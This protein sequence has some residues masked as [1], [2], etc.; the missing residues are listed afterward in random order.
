[1]LKNLVFDFGN[2]LV[3]FKPEIALREFF[4]SDEDAA[5][6][7]PRVYGSEPW[8]NGDSGKWT[9]AQVVDGIC[10]LFPEKADALRAALARHTQMLLMPEGTPALLSRL[11][12]AGYRL[13]FISNT[14]DDD[15]AF[16]RREHPVLFSL[17]GGIASCEAKLVKPDPAIFRL[18]L[19]QYDLRAEEC[20]FVDDM[21]QNTAAAA[22]EGFRTLTLTTGADTLEEALLGIPEIAERLN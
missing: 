11:R 16:M 20:L 9:R 13:Y 8:R 22:R 19:T 14:S 12:A 6:W 4:D 3:Y 2:V 17:D 7:I 10:R 18:L 1:M 21:W 15:V 5:Y